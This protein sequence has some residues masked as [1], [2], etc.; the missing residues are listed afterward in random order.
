MLTW[1][2]L[3]VSL[4]GLVPTAIERSVQDRM[5]AV[6]VS[7]VEIRGPGAGGQGSGMEDQGTEMSNLIAVPEPGSR[8]GRAVRFILHANR[9]RVGSVVATLQV[10]GHAVRARR[11][12][13]RGAAVDADAI[14]V[15]DTELTGV[16]LR[17]LPSLADAVR[18]VAR[19]DIAPGEMLTDSVL[20]V[21]PAVSSGDEV[22]VLVR[23]GP[24]EVTSVG[25][26][27]GSG[28]AGDLIRVVLRATR[29]PLKARILG[30]G[31]VEI[32]R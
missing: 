18:A 19:R 1:V 26:A 7:V 14:E 25:R 9:T 32:V 22:A 21:P 28:R 10:T 5:G 27:S 4:A 13:A 11:G 2:A 17:R 3:G 16:M 29:T 6:Q 8:L 15:V 20:I 30:P 12:I 31:S 24:I 23:S